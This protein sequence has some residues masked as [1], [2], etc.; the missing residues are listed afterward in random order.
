MAFTQNDPTYSEIDST[1]LESVRKEV[2]WNNFFVGTPFLEELRRSGVADPYLGGAGMTEV[3][4]YGRPQ[5]AGVNPGQTITV[6]RQQITD[7]LK[8]YEK[9]YASWFPMDDWEMD[10]GSKQGG[11]INSGPA[12]IA[13]IYAIFMEALVMQIN[14]ML[15]MDSFRHGQQSSST[16][17]DNRYKVSNGLDEALNNGIDTSVYGNIYKSYGQQLRNG[18]VGASIN[19]TPLYLGQ[20]VTTGTTSAPA[21]SGPGQI[22]FGSLM[23][24]WSMCKITG[25]KPK[26][27]ITNVFGFKAIAVTLDAYRRDI[28]NIKHDITWDA[29]EFNGTQIYS[30]PL[31]PSAQAQYYIPLASGGAAGNTSLV[32]GVNSNTATIAYQTPQFLNAAGGNSLLS[33]TNSGLPSNAMIQPSEVIYFL[34]PETFKLR[35]TDKPG[36]NF[37]VRR[38]SQW[39]NVSVDTIFMRLATNLYCC[40][41]RQNSMAFG[42]TA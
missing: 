29:L 25:G 8:F 40:Q 21:T 7:K 37:G 11:V 17:S 13:D 10:D 22:N 41:P 2:V 12:R 16:V 1:N 34:T 5:G 31:S 3:F 20:Q 39:N 42:F 28:S 32:D 19:V 27:G 9:G 14:T 26:L 6:T 24:L 23:Q 38:T 15:E 30:D 36:W 33:P 35:T 18:A 4:L